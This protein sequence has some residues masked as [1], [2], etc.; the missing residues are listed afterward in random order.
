MKVPR[1]HPDTIEEVQQR[2]DIVDVISEHIVLRKR[3]KDF[4]GLCPFHN[5]KTPSFSV[6]QDK[7][8]YYCFG[9]S[10]GGN[11]YKFLMEINKQSFAEVVLD[12]ARRYQVEIKTVEPEQ[13]QEIQRQFTL[14]E[15]LYEILAIASS[16]FQH[17]LYQSQGEVALTYLRQQ[18]NI[19][20]NT[21]SSFQLGYAP[22][23]W[24][25]LYRYLV[26]Q[27]RYPVN[28]V[29]QAG[30]IKPRKTGSGYYDV[31]RDRLIMPIKDL[32]GRIIGF[33]SRSLNDEDQPK[34]LN[35]PETPLFDKSKTLFAL[36]QARSPIGQADCAIVVEGYF[37]AIALHEAG[38][39][40][41]VA[42]LGTAFTQDQLKQ[43]LRFTASKQVILN[44]DADNAG[45]KATERAIAEV[46]DLVYGGVV[47][48]RILN[49]PGGKDA[50]EFIKKSREDG[51]VLY[52]QALET[53]PLW[54]D[55]LIE[56]LLADKNLKA[57]DEFQQVAAGMIKLLNK[58][59]DANQRNHYLTHCAE[60][61][62]LGDTRLV[63][64]NLAT[65]KSQIK[66]TRTNYQ[67]NN[68][69]LSQKKSASKPTFA[70]A[71]DPESELL[72]Q[73]EALLLRIYIHYPRYRELIIEELE[74]KDLLF[75]VAAHRFLWQQI[76]KLE[77]TVSSSSMSNINP[78]LSE[79]HNLSPSFPPNVVNVTKLFYLDEKTQ[80]DVFRTEVRVAEAIASL[81]QVNHQRRQIYCSGQLQNLNPAT[82]L[83]L[84]EYYYQEIQTAV[85]KIRQ[86]EQI[87]LNYAQDPIIQ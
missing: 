77:E 2:V 1:L 27:K 50:D 68:H 10:A 9:C 79:L 28:L 24:E 70:I 15:Q 31:F 41:V 4:L 21:I 53:A 49:L 37:D 6:S 87:R 76:I 7:Q 67:N 44:F 69:N 60:L 86:L 8:V 82:D 80:E 14:K 38:I 54:F 71:S 85:E 25:T 16:F 83:K 65:L 73:A 18:R 40:H 52:Y 59:Q 22:G 63:L 34:Y 61:L 17:A 75:N 62:S 12:L 30:L 47:Q 39:K 5:E 3:G 13:R 43:L 55:W 81:E 57:A 11:A 48:L 23:G 33:G 26:E 84:M 46:E 51:V 32:Q 66:S 56:R 20:E 58:L 35:S 74:S 36:D 72:E 64:Q 29:E 78:L 45:K 42:S 19:E